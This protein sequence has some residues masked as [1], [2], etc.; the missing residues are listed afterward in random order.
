[1]KDELIDK[2]EE[3][4]K[5]IDY[6]IEYFLKNKYENPTGELLFGEE[7]SLPRYAVIYSGMKDLML[8]DEKLKR[9]DS[10]EEE[11]KT[12]IQIFY[13]KNYNPVEGVLDQLKSEGYEIISQKN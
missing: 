2:I 5:D 9:K 3:F 4:F 6:S 1:M 10:F 13:I 11:N 8:D 7:V 12:R